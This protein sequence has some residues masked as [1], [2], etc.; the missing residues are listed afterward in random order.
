MST[1]PALASWRHLNLWQKKAVP[2]LLLLLAFMSLNR[3]L[4]YRTGLVWFENASWWEI[5]Q[6]FWMGFRFDLLVLGFFAMPLVLVSVGLRRM[7]RWGDA[8][9]RVLLV[10]WGGVWTLV[11]LL[12]LLSHGFFVL[13]GRH[14][15]FWD[16]ATLTTRGSELAGFFTATSGLLLLAIAA[17]EVSIGWREWGRAA[18]AIRSERAKSVEATAPERLGMVALRLVGPLLLAGLAARGTVTPHH[19]EKQ[20]SLV[21]SNPSLNQ[22]VL[23][24]VWT[25][26]KKPDAL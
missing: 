23:N 25:F 15:T 19:L 22:L 26:D 7:D 20:H 2:V 13:A 24:A 16:L 14:L 1:Q 6:T 4:L 12:S 9:L 8:T 21:S 18:R 10:C 3:F 17:C 5:A 11:V